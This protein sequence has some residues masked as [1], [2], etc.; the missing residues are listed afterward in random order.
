[1][2]RGFVRGGNVNNS[3]YSPLMVNAN[4]SPSNANS[5][6]GFGKNNAK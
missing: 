4:N 1:M 5:N 2:V 6:I 3:D